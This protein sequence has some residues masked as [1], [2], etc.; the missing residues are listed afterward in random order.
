M[1]IPPS[2]DQILRNP[3]ADAVEA[4]GAFGGYIGPKTL[5]GLVRN[6]AP[7]L[8][9]GSVSAF[10]TPPESTGARLH[11]HGHHP[12]GWWSILR[13][14]DLVIARETPSP[15]EWTDYFALCVAAHFGSV[16]TFVP[17]D[18][19]TKIRAHLWYDRR[20]DELALMRAFAL[21]L[22]TW[23]IRGVSA[24]VVEVD[25]VGPVSGH[26]GER[27]SVLCGALL[28]H[29]HA[30]DRAGADEL[31]AAVE[32]EV[33]REARAFDILARTP[34]RERDL[35]VLAA[36]ITHNVG[37]IDQGFSAKEGKRVGI[38]QKLRFGR[39]AQER[40]ERYGRAYG[41]AS[42]LYRELLA[43]EGHRHYPMREI[44]PLRRDPALLL[45]IG[46]F[47]D[48]WGYRLSRYPGFTP[49]ERAEVF[50]GIVGACFRVRGQQGYFRALAGFARGLPQGLDSDV[51]LRYLP[52]GVRRDLRDQDVRQKTAV[53]QE[54]FESSYAKRTRAI[55][56]TW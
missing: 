40:F 12:L 19:D 30:G 34:G 22:R 50:G 10:A 42:A 52:A 41:K 55:L 28:G 2:R 36:S 16:A 56:S 54:S 39:L 24:R 3:D 26:D 15:E 14:A 46:P 44:R 11:E 43:P 9:D 7:Y 25:G 53:R 1:P 33:V 32:A 45:P 29:L 18:V 8:F 4:R 5:V 6:T 31:E 37:D 13:H 38:E 49:A 51:V 35:L 21:G 23:D 17:T 48:D 20:P 47:F 27:L